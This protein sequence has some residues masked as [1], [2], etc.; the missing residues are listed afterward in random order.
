MVEQQC[1]ANIAILRE[2]REL[3]NMA[4]TEYM[5]SNLALYETAFNT[6]ENAIES[7]DI[8]GYISGNK[9]IQKQLG[10]NDGFGSMAE[11]D[12]LMASDDDFK[13]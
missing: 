1:K 11:F 9:M 2:N 13:L 5:S 4:V 7:N 6:I 10:R 3:I 12:E 8:E